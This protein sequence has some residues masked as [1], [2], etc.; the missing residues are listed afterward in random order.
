M[1]SGPEYTTYGHLP[2]MS[3]LPPGARRKSDIYFMSGFEYVWVTNGAFTGKPPAL[4]YFPVPCVLYRYS[5]GHKLWIC[6]IHHSTSYTAK[7]P[8]CRL[9]CT[10]KDVYTWGVPRRHRTTTR[11]A[12]HA[13]GNHV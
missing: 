7:G 1:L 12:G 2:G 13:H 6:D 9:V 4:P 3:G 10:G 8:I 5:W 11:K